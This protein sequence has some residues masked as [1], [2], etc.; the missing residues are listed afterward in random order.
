MASTTKTLIHW[1]LCD[2]YAAGPFTADTAARR[3]GQRT[4]CGHGHRVVTSG[5]K[6]VTAAEI[7]PLRAEWDAPFTG[8]MTD[9]A[10]S[11][12]GDLTRELASLILGAQIMTRV[13]DLTVVGGGWSKERG[14]YADATA[15][16]GS[17]GWIAAL[18]AHEN[19]TLTS[20]GRGANRQAW[21]ECAGLNDAAAWVRYEGW[22]EQGMDA[23]GFVCGTCRRITQ[24]G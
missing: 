4:E 12:R 13:G 21:C 22:T 2:D 16:A 5:T 3:A 8:D 15:E 10:I 6:P 11:A 24:T 1:V 18:G 14:D 7:S 9:E 20:D 23:H 17:A 19:A